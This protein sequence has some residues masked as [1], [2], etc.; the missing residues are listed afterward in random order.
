MQ[1]MNTKH[2]NRKDS[3][4]CHYRPAPIF[5]QRSVRVIYFHVFRSVR[6]D[7]VMYGFFLVVNAGTSQ[8]ATAVRCWSS[9]CTSDL[10][11]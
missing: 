9:P 7:S 1:A 6:K 8:G 11:G 3:V 2:I 4:S 5:D 10:A